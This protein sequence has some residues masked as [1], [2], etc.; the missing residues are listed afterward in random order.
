MISCGVLLA[1]GGAALALQLP[2]SRVHIPVA[3]DGHGAS[4]ASGPTS[5]GTGLPGQ[6]PSGPEFA[7]ECFLRNGVAYSPFRDGQGPDG[8]MPTSDQIL[9]DLT[10]LR[11]ITAK[12]RIYDTEDAWDPIPRLAKPLGLHVV[13]GVWLDSNDDLNLKRIKRATELAAA[14]EVD[15]LVI[16]NESLTLRRLPLPDLLRYI[17]RAR[18]DSPRAFPISTAESWVVW[19]DTPSLAAH[20]TFVMAHFHPF[21]DWHGADVSAL[22]DQVHY[23]P[24]SLAHLDLIQLQAHKF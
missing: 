21:W 3:P 15:A 4:A 10:Q 23:R 6:T 24:V 17:D 19:R 8:D 5:P 12:I 2:A 22:P 18:Q 20:V 7:R 11:R 16:G 13:Q 14:G 9:E 1:A